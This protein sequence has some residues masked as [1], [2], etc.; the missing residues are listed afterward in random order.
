VSGRSQL[1]SSS[2]IVWDSRAAREFAECQC[3]AAVLFHRPPAFDLLETMLW[4]QSGGFFLLERHLARL[5]DSA[6]YFGF[7]FDAEAV[8]TALSPCEA[9][10]QAAEKTDAVVRLLLSKNGT[11]RTETVDAPPRRRRWRVAVA[12]KPVARDD[13][14]LFHKTTHRETYDRFRARQAGH[15]DVI[16]W[17]PRREVTESTCANV[18][19]RSGRHFLTPPVSCG[20]LAGT[21]RGELLHRGRITE[22]VIRLGDL[23]HAD[24]VYL[25]N[26]V[27]GWIKAELD[28]DTPP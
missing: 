18:V 14:F 22:R 10:L 21:L 24:A 15:D 19:I 16:L 17:N 5:A 20:L 26:S 28:A 8:R 13:V 23:R 1:C 9:S 25:I 6:R 3:K 7:P 2:G 11:A 12:D 4:R 27:R